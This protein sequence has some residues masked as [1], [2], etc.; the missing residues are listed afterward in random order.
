M[1]PAKVLFKATPLREIV[2]AHP[3]VL[4]KLRR[5]PN[6]ETVT[7][8]L[9]QDEQE[10]LFAM[11][12]KFE[13]TMQ[14][15]ANEKQK[16]TYL[17][18]EAQRAGRSQTAMA[19]NHELQLA[20]KRAIRV[21]RQH[22]LQAEIEAAYSKLYTAQAQLQADDNDL[23]KQ[24]QLEAAAR[25]KLEEAIEKR[26]GAQ[27][28]LD[29]RNQLIFMEESKQA[30]LSRQRDAADALVKELAKKKQDQMDKLDEI[31]ARVE[32]TK[33]E[34]AA[35]KDELASR[36]LV[37]EKLKHDIALLKKVQGKK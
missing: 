15:L 25:S 3:F 6:S 23:Q 35:T 8:D 22:V 10:K 36:K 14:A 2:N 33:E 37:I 4:Q 24:L 34:E 20:Q 19:A 11:Q 9:S 1:P 16:Q 26:R 30:E 28:M 12:R 21:E 27:E 29:Y 7:K 13:A 32:T 31:K 18:A 5:Y 17:E